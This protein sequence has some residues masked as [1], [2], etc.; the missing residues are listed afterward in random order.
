MPEVSKSSHQTT[1]Y[2][3]TRGFIAVREACTD[4]FTYEQLSA[5]T[6]IPENTLQKYAQGVIDIPKSKLTDLCKAFEVVQEGLSAVFLNN[7]LSQFNL[8]ALPAKDSPSG[9][10]ADILRKVADMVEGAGELTGK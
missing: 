2:T 1:D 10:A 4:G 3:L 9:Q 6:G 7:W 8:K 5:I